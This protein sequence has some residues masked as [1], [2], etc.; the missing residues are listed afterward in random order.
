MN[1]HLCSLIWH[2]F[3]VKEK[4]KIWKLKKFRNK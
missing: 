4:E 3:I 2:L 1:F